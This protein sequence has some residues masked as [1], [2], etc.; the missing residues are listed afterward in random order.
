MVLGPVEHE[1][2]FRFR[3]MDDFGIYKNTIDIDYDSD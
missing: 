3:N 1:T 2:N